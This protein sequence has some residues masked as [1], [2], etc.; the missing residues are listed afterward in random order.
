ME[1]S[2]AGWLIVLGLLTMG[3][4]GAAPRMIGS[5]VLGVDLGGSF[6]RAAYVAPG[7]VD[8]FPILL[9]DLG[10][11]LSAHAVAWRKDRW[12]FGTHANKAAIS[13]PESS[14]LALGSDLL[15]RQFDSP[16]VTQYREQFVGKLEADPA[17]GTVMAID[18]NGRPV[19]IEHLSSL[20]LENLKSHSERMSSRHFSGAVITVPACCAARLPSGIGPRVLRPDPAPGPPRCRRHCRL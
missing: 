8:P 14:Y 11:R 16:E 13:N 7:E 3:Q 17:R 12:L 5:T 1:R 15:G 10:E 2:R 9:S 18:I 6:M 19:P 4:L 20:Y